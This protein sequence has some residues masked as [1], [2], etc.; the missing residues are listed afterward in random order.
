M[1]W[2]PNSQQ[3]FVSELSKRDVLVKLHNY[4]QEVNSEF[5]TEKPLFNGKVG[6]DGFRVSSIIQTPQNA[7][8]LIIGNVESTKRGSII[9]LKLKLFPAAILYLKASSLLSI[10]LGFTFLFLSKWYL[11]G[12]ISLSFGLLNYLVL[13]LSFHRKCKECIQSLKNLL[14][15]NH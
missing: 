1:E 11:A 14:E 9:F 5:V 6:S 15:G 10:L 7:L 4:T 13:T 3:T 12:C 2:L 8:P